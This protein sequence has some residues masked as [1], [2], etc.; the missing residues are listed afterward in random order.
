MAIRREGRSRR[1]AA[2][3]VRRPTVECRG[4]RPPTRWRRS[5]L[6]PTT[7]RRRAR[8][9]RR[10][11]AVAAA[12]RRTRR[13][14]SGRR[15]QCRARDRRRARTGRPPQGHD[16]ERQ[17][18]RTARGREP[19]SGASASARRGG[20]LRR[21]GERPQAGLPF[22]RGE[23]L[24]FGVE[25]AR[26]GLLEGALGAVGEF[27]R[28]SGAGRAAAG[29]RSRSRAPARRARGRAPSTTRVTSPIR[30]AVVDVD[31][32]ARQEQVARPGL[33][34]EPRQ[35]PAHAA[36]RLR[37]RRVSGSAEDDV[38]APRSRMSHSIASSKPPAS[39][40]PC[41]AAT[42]GTGGRAHPPA[43]RLE[44]P[45]CSARNAATSMAS[46]AVRSPPAQNER[47]SR[48]EQDAPD[49]GIA[50]RP[51]STAST[52]AS[53]SAGLERVQDVR[54]VQAQDGDAPGRA[55]RAGARRRSRFAPPGPETRRVFCS[56]R[57]I[58]AGGH[59]LDAPA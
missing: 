28:G 31:R 35:Q 55:R 18:E 57:G 53:T 47:P 30:S 59:D 15:R 3:A 8:R 40:W 1:L 4:R 29:R 24:H 21:F 50:T 42:V 52:S 33:P 54:A 20:A 37:P 27:R 16:A 39:T 44:L 45:R 10:I 9:G 46:I 12:A 49:A 51:R 48:G 17:G 23:A 19:R 14:R 25:L 41:R 7:Q 26:K 6:G 13:R 34:D 11:R 38:A 2:I 56:P 43:Q 22:G 5:A 32:L 58:G 36:R